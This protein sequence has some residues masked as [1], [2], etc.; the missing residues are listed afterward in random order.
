MSVAILGFW[1]IVT[2]VALGLLLKGIT[3]GGLEDKTERRL[4]WTIGGLLFLGAAIFII[5]VTYFQ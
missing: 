2:V 3:E 1:L 5:G 4:D